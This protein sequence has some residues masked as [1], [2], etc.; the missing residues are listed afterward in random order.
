MS[1]FRN[2]PSSYYNFDQKSTDISV[3]I[4]LMVS[5]KFVDLFPERSN[6]C[7]VEYI[8]K[9][10]EKPE[11]I[12]NRIYNRSDYHWLI[13]MSNRIINP[14][15]DWPL[16]QTELN[17][18]IDKK[19]PGVAMFFDCV[20]TEATQFKIKNTNTLLHPSKSLFIRGNTVTQT[21]GNR[22]VT[23]KII[24]WYPTYR[25][26]VIDDI[27]GGVFTTNQKI[28]TANQDG[29]IFEATPKKEVLQHTDSVHHF[30]DD[31]N[32]YLD[33][34]AR[35]NYYEYDDNKIYSSKNIFFNNSSGLPKP[36]TV[37]LTGTND[38]MLNKYIN[39]S[40]NNTITNRMFEDFENQNRRVVKILRTEYV[41]ALINQI[42]TIFKR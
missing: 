19:Y 39:G 4:N 2:F 27:Q 11:H 40:Q 15:W 38:F 28:T 33:P 8:V 34:Y 23:G 16:T 26:L 31:F 35:L 13:L 3:A 41:P 37:G 32:N 24:D 9:D 17:S 22:T 14:Y 10:G 42:E 1:Y 30:V 21:L 36:S 29:V 18:Y 20:G 25:K 7:Y 5:A 6:K 12:S